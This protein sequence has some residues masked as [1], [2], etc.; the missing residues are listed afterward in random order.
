MTVVAETNED[1]PEAPAPE[2]H[3]HP[4]DS[5]YWM[6]G[7]VLAALTLLEVTTYWWPDD[8][9]K[10]TFWLLIVLMSIKFVMVALYFMHLKFDPKLL[11]RTFF[12]G[13]FLALAVYLVML[14]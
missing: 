2:H 4:T 13:L 12:F 5:T 8:W 10:V 14:S 9:H 11:K 6:V 3:A 7:G 1:V